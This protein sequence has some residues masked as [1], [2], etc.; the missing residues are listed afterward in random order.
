MESLHNIITLLEEH[1]IGK[2]ILVLGDVMLDK[3]IHGTVERISP[4][5]PVPVVH[6]IRQSHS[7]GG[8]ANVAMNIVGM[9]GKASLIGFTGTDDDDVQ[10][11]QCLFHSNLKLDLISISGTSTTSKLRILGGSQQMMRVDVEYTEP[12]PTDAYSALLR[13][14]EDVLPDVDG[15]ILSDYAKGVLTDEVCRGVINRAG[16]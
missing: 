11:R 6:A 14:V 1:W 9:K 3:Y 15:V 13:H 8:A 7:P 5:A 2:R 16:S 10:L 4:E 12:F